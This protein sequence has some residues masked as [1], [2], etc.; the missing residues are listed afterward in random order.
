M[1]LY[2]ITR[3]PSV[4]HGALAQSPIVPIVMSPDSIEGQSIV[5]LYGPLS[6]PSAVL[7]TDDGIAH[8][9]WQTEIPSLQ[10]VRNNIPF[11]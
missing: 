2:I 6:Y 7:T 4:A 10:E 5:G 3:E 8:K 1:K 9:I 11:V